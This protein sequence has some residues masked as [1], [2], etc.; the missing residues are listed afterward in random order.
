MVYDVIVVGA[1]PAGATLAY[2]L[3]ERG[4]NVLILDKAALPRHKACGG[5]LTLKTIRRLPFDVSSVVELQAAGLILS[6][7][8]REIL[9]AELHEPAAALVMRNRFDYLLVQKALEKGAHLMQG[10]GVTG[11]EETDEQVAVYAGGDKYY[12]RLLAGA[13]GVNSTVARSAGLLLRREVGTAIE[14]ELVVPREALE[15]QGAHATFDFGVLRHGYG[16]IFP[17]KDHLTVGVFQARH[18]KARELS[19]RLKVFVDCQPVLR[20]GRCLSVRGHLIPLG[21][22]REKLHRG[23][24]LLIGDAANLA[25]PWLG[26]GI[27]YAISSAHLAAGVVYRA[28]NESVPD[29]SEYTSRINAQLVQ[30]FIAARRLARAVYRCP[31]LLS[32]AVA[33]SWLLKDALFDTVRGELTFTQLKGRLARRLPCILAQFLMHVVASPTGQEAM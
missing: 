5:G 1:G 7:A 16:W 23:R 15:D 26:E 10:I 11:I 6:Y 31:W 19:R 27:C 3:A 30:E 28:L 14:T 33:K 21:G 32:M 12:G 18:G 9:K 8:G 24:T 17:K 4:V 13:D 2:A 25:D 20:G 29:L 22:R